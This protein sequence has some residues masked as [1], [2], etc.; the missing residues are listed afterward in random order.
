MPSILVVGHFPTKTLTGH[1]VQTVSGYD[2]AIE[3]LK[4]ERFDVIIMDAVIDTTNGYDFL[5]FIRDNG[6]IPTIV[7]YREP[8]YYLPAYGRSWII[9]NTLGSVFSFAEPAPLG[10]GHGSTVSKALSTLTSAITT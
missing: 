10:R 3:M 6:G 5:V 7:R 9:A 8:S 4:N 1:Q 2:E